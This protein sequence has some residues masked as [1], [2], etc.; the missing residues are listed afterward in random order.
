MSTTT[1]RTAVTTA[2]N[3]SPLPGTR[4]ATAGLLALA[5]MLPVTAGPAAA[6]TGA[7]HQVIAAARLQTDAI[8]AELRRA[9]GAAAGLPATLRT[10]VTDAVESASA[11]AEQ[12]RSALASASSASTTTADQGSGPISDDD[13]ASVELADAQVALEAAS[14]QLRFV[15]TLITENGDDVPASLQD[16]AAHV[17]ELRGETAR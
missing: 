10:E 6:Q 5:A 13:R 11:A 15:T 2:R 16:L 8:T 3:T 17:D 7:V 14:A 4:L 1:S 9:Q 12:A